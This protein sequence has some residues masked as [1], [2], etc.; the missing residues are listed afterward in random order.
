MTSSVEELQ[1]IKGVRAAKEAGV[2]AGT[3]YAEQVYS[4]D[5]DELTGPEVL[6]ATLAPGHLE[7]DE[8]YINAGAVPTRGPER[9]AFCAALNVAYRARAEALLAAE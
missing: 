2:A 4:E 5:E 6:R 1:R 3:E 7:P 8:A 9:D